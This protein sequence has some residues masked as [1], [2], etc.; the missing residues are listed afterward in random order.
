MPARAPRLPTEIVWMRAGAP[1]KHSGDDRVEIGSSVIT[2]SSYFSAY[3][4]AVGYCNGLGCI[5]DFAGAGSEES[6]I[7][8]NASD[9][10]STLYRT[11]SGAVVDSDLVDRDNSTDNTS[12][13]VFV[14]ADRAITTHYAVLNAASFKL[15]YNSTLNISDSCEVAFK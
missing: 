1:S 7:T 2:G 6:C 8:D 3:V 9:C 11:I 15:T 12:Y 14:A 4:C 10:V 13:E 5:A